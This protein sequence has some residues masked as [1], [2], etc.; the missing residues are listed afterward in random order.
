MISRDLSAGDIVQEKYK[1]VKEVGHGGMGIVYLADDLRLERQVALKELIVNRNISDED[2]TEIV[3]R[4]KREA[5][6]AAKL[7]HPNII[8]I[9]DV[10]EDNNSY[11]IAMEYLPGDTLKDIL[12]KKRIF[13]MEEILEIIIQISS[14]IEHAHS[15]G[16]VHRDIKPENIKVLE[17]DSVKIMDFGIASIENK[18]TNL[19]QD[20]SMLGT[21]AYMSPEQLYSSKTVD[22]R[23]DIFSFGAMLYE[24]FTGK[25]PFDAETVGASIIKIMTEQPKKVRELNIKV[26]DK[27]ENVINKCLE[28]DIS[29]RYQKM[30]DV[31]NELLFYKMCLTHKELQEKLVISKENITSQDIDEEEHIPFDS[32][33]INP[34]KTFLDINSIKKRKYHIL[35]IEDD[36][37][38]KPMFITYMKKKDF[39]Y[40]YTFVDTIKKAIHILNTCEIDFIIC[41][42]ILPDG[43]A[44]DIIAHIQHN[45]PII[46]TTT[47]DDTDLIIELM[48]KGILDYV[49]KTSDLKY[50]DRIYEMI[51]EAIENEEND[52]NGNPKKLEINFV[53]TI[54]NEIGLTSPRHIH[55]TDNKLFIA[56]T[57]NSRVVVTNIFGETIS[58]YTEDL[59]APCYIASDEKGNIYVLDADDCYI[60]IYS[61]SGKLIHHFGGKGN[62]LGKMQS[63]Y[64]L[65]ICHNNRVIVTDPD[66][67]K[68]HVFDITGTP[69]KTINYPF[70]SPS[71][72]T[73]DPDKV[74]ILDYGSASIKI[75]DID[76]NKV[77]EFGK[78]GPADGDF[79][80]PK[81]ISLD[82]K[83]RI[84]ITETLNHRVQVFDQLGHLL[85]KFGSKGS[86]DGQFNMADS[87][88]ISDKGKIFVLDKG[89]NRVQ[90]FNSIFI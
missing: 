74:Y 67:H 8:T 28:K 14:G 72:I 27:I 61:L 42:Y 50:L 41:D 12:E 81:G 17:D 87:L 78:R 54:A 58:E 59:K 82:K 34:L 20:G 23:A 15:K 44:N 71:G 79:S 5:Q 84:Y 70:K 29:K 37:L 56:D 90:E 38:L 80:V 21:I 11:F 63:V 36:L 89:N 65:T 68:V 76:Y 40:D 52:I 66:A 26:S 10:F 62:S 1:I 19:T 46:L 83:N 88:T 48:R 24:V 9:F 22:S 35:H 31:Y 53:K 77:F 85:V 2:V 73:S 30:K 33:D 47:L 25:L 51:V 55:Y 64:G 45:I 39:N 57:K 6:T 69:I 3:E 32:L 16:V 4:F 43:T 49:I 86:G 75:F 60:K 18:K 13:K 7:N